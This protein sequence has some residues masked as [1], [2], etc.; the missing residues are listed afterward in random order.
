MP[1]FNSKADGKKILVAHEERKRSKEDRIQHIA[2][3]G[4]AGFKF[5][6]VKAPLWMQVNSETTP[7]T[8]VTYTTM[9]LWCLTV[10]WFT[11]SLFGYTLCRQWRNVPPAGES[12]NLD[13]IFNTPPLNRWAV[14]LVVSFGMMLYFT[15]QAMV[16]IFQ[17]LAINRDRQKKFADEN[18]WTDKS[19]ENGE[20]EVSRCPSYMSL[21]NPMVGVSRKSSS[22]SSL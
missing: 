16:F 9:C 21:S 22:S 15:V 8:V 5:T 20:A 1:L 19:P 13:F 10:G 2:D 14:N 3:H 18:Q 4:W 11:C 17:K 12:A 7:L 6:K